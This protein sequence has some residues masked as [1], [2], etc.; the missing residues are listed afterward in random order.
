MDETTFFN[1]LGFDSNPFQYTNADD[2]ERLEEYFIPPPYFNSVWGNPEKAK[3]ATI[4]APRG[5]G[6]TAQRRMIEFKSQSE[7]NVLC[8]TYSIFDFK[9]Q[10]KEI[11][12]DDHLNKIIP[13]IMIGI[14]TKLNDEPEIVVNLDKDDKKYLKKLIDTHLGTMSEYEFKN[15]IDALSSYSDKAK[16]IWNDHLSSINV[17]INLILNKLG[18][19]AVEIRKFEETLKFDETLRYQLEIIRQIVTKIGYKSI[20]ILIDKVDESENTG[21][22]ASNASK[23]IE[24]LLKDLNILEMKGYGFKFFLWDNL[25][26]YYE[27]F[28]RKDR[29]EY[30]SLDWNNSELK[31]MLS[32]RLETFSNGKISELSSVVDQYSI[33]D[34]NDLILLFAQKSPRNVIRIL[35]DIT[36]EQREIDINVKRISNQALFKGIDVFCKK[37]VTEIVDQNSLKDL[38]KIGKCEF[39]I[40]DLATDVFRCKNATIRTKIKKWSDL[41][42]IIQAGKVR[43]EKNKKPVNIYCIN[44]IIVARNVFEKQSLQ[45]FLDMKCIIC[46]TCGGYLL[47]DWEINGVSPCQYCLSEVGHNK[48]SIKGILVKDSKSTRK[49]DSDKQRNLLDFSRE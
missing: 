9:K 48:R 31:T 32:K 45:Q 17:A 40:S 23:L 46:P 5:G 19:S 39:T 6:K 22:D 7:K 49:I 12:L 27:I 29:I 14:L 20:Y 18:T 33:I 16:R 21:N 15:S 13:I 10:A 3:S 1:N 41:G 30:Y 38:M 44:N 37:R 8:V 42:L 24:P 35:Q 26:R 47:R 43:K 36:S 11:V 34:I 4:F 28:G 2:E 25:L